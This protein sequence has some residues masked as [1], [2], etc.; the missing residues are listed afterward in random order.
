MDLANLSGKLKYLKRKGVDVS[1]K[2]RKEAEKEEKQ[3]KRSG[4][5]KVYSM[6]EDETFKDQKEEDTRGKLLNYSI[7]DYEKWQLKQT[8]KLK[9]SDGSSQQD[10]AKYTYD[11][12]IREMEKD[13]SLNRGKVT[14]ARLNGKGRVQIND[15]K[16][17]LEQ[18]ADNL[19]KSTK[20]RYI[21]RKK[22][23][24]KLDSS[25]TGGFIND[26]NKQFNEKLSRQFKQF[27][28]N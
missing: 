8:A 26:K 28:D 14:K 12:E 7:K 5:P 18:L 22:Q 10:L 20:R 21:E 4:K 16:K 13:E 27:D 25:T 9:N 24:E 19:N 17:S 3:A 11:K 1:V 2:N 15:D 6:N 23:A